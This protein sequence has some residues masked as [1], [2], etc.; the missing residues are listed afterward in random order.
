MSQTTQLSR[1]VLV[2][3]QKG[4][5]LKSSIV[6]AVAAMIARPTR[7]VLVVDADPQGNVSRNDLGVPG[8]RGQ[9]L[10]MAIQYGQPINPIQNVR[11]GLD[12]IPGGPL[13]SSIGAL[14]V[15]AASSGVDLGGNLVR[16]L[17]ELCG[18]KQYTLVLI[19]S[20]PGDAALLE[21]LLGTSRYLLVPTADDSASLDGVKLLAGRYLRARQQGAQIELLGVVLAN[22]N[23]RATARNAAALATIAEMLG[24]SGADPF[25]AIIRTDKAAAVDMRS[26]NLTPAELVAAAEGNVRSRIAHLRKG[27][28]ADT[29]LW[30]RD[31]SGLAGDYQGLTRE[32]LQRIALREAA[33]LELAK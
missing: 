9:G 31:A 32:I 30:S 21:I 29:D 16:T 5:V 24:G 2:G 26:R 14:A 15:T 12:V 8:D 11:D 1:V 3:N 22:V 7:R 28:R 17:A 23:P 25:D 13:L 4:G 6:A 18:G 27:T 10:A 33:A 19:D 20:A